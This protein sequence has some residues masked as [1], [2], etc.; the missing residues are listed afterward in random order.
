[1]KCIKDPEELHGKISVVIA[2][3]SFQVKS[4]NAYCIQENAPGKK[5]ILLA[6]SF[7]QGI[8]TDK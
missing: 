3:I 2:I 5:D 6:V 1:M 7:V 4:R 8:Q